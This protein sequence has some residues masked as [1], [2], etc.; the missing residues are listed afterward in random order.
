MTGRLS[1]ALRDVG[2]RRGNK[3]VLRNISLTLQPGERWALIGDNGAG[4]TQLLKLIERRFE[5]W[6]ANYR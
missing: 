4:K 3:W 5:G 2:V 1:I 6:R